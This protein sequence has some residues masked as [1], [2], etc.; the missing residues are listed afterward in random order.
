VYGYGMRFLAYVRVGIGVPGIRR[1]LAS[2]TPFVG[3]AGVQCH[4]QL[5]ASGLGTVERPAEIG[6]LDIQ[7]RQPPL[8]TLE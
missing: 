5:E 8:D 2:A 4:A 7:S 1:R 3:Y 6:P